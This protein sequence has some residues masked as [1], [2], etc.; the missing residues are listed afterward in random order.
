MPIIAALIVVSSPELW[1]CSSGSNEI[2]DR[3]S[4]TFWLHE[5]ADQD[6]LKVI[7]RKIN[8]GYNGLAAC[9][10]YLKRAKEAFENQGVCIINTSI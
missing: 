3:D 5:L 8:G 9:E 4:D 2:L 6:N 1:S 10:K 7:R